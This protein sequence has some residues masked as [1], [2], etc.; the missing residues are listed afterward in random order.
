MTTKKMGLGKGLG[1]L[2]SAYDD[3]DDTVKNTSNNA[4]NEIVLSSLVPN[5]NQPRKNFD[6]TALQELANSIK[7]HGVIQPLVVNDQKDGTYLIIAGERRYRASKLAG[8]NTVPCIIK[9]YSEKQIKEISIIENLQREDLNPIESARAIRQLMDEYKMTQEAVSE[10]I[11]VSRPN[12]ANTLRLLSLCPEVIALVESGKLSAGHAR[13]LIPVQ[14]YNLQIKLAMA[15]SD[16]RMTVRD[17]EKAVKNLLKPK[18]NTSKQPMEQSI[19]LKELVNEMQRTFSTKVSVI[20]ND[21]KGRIYIDY[22]SRDDLDRIA[23]LIQLLKTKKLTL[24]ELSE[25][26][27]KI[28]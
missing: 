6:Q 18:D 7:V 24:K 5:P 26:N 11:G 9:D 13:C 3:Y 19:E 15:A 28:K 10:R 20:G 4:T 2:L 14:D 16:N 8:L 21:K 27:K 17:L 25:F 22:Y 23:E 12:I 1:A